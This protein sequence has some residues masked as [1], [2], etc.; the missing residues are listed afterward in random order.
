MSTVGSDAAN[1]AYIFDDPFLSAYN[2]AIFE[3]V[4]GEVD[5]GW[6]SPMFYLLDGFLDVGLGDGHGL[7]LT[8]TACSVLRRRARGGVIETRVFA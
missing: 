2:I 5:V 4:L 8:W 6:S 7:W 1:E 3:D